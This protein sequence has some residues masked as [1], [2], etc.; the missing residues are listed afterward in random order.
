M[1][2]QHFNAGNTFA[3]IDQSG[4]RIHFVKHDPMNRCAVLPDWKI[5]VHRTPALKCW[6]IMFK[7]VDSPAGG[8]VSAQHFNAGNTFAKID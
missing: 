8:D 6:A 4:R 1:T 2:A 7:P 3:K 5:F